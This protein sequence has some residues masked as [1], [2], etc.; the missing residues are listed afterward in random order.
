[1]NIEQKRFAILDE[2]VRVFEVGL[3]LADG[4]D[5]CPAQS[6][7]GFKLFQK[8]V[9]VAGGAIMRGIPLTAGH[10]VAGPD[11]LLGA[12]SRWLNNHVTGLASHPEASLNLNPSI[13]AGFS[14]SGAELC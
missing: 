6:H 14:G 12:G 2:A 3:A 10:R 8:K 11:R 4:L 7:A 9:V 5:L 13:G 1:M